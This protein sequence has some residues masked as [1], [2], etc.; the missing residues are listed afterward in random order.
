MTDP[1]SIAVDR[2]AEC[3]SEQAGPYRLLPPAGV[4]A[5]HGPWPLVIFLHGAGERGNDNRLQLRYLPEYLAGDDGRRRYPCF[6]LAVQCPEADKWADVDWSHPSAPPAAADTPAMAALRA[7]AAEV[8]AAHPIDRGRIYLTG[9]SMGG[10]G[11]WHWA[12]A[13][14]EW[15]A[16]VAPVCGGGDPARASVLK[17]TPLWAVHGELDEAVP[18]E[19]SRQMIEAIRRAGGSPR[20]GEL[21]GVGHHSWKPAYDPAFGLVDWMFEQRK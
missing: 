16:A 20:Y 3:R 10:Y 19:R 18:V 2:F 12:T 14:P 17:N 15:F 11:T 4:S 5:G 21:A 6:C 1:F 13:E 9:I 8:V 7:I